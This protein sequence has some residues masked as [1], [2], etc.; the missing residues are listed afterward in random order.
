MVDFSPFNPMKVLYHRPSIELLLRGLMPPP[1]FITIDPSNRCNQN[2][3]WCFVHD[4]RTAT[5]V[6]LD[7]SVMRKVLK[8]VCRTV[9][10]IAYCGGGEPLMN[11]ATIQAMRWG[12][13]CH[14]QQGLVTNGTAYRSLTEADAVVDCCSFVRVSV[15]ASTPEIY[16]LLHRSNGFEY[17][18]AFIKRLVQR[19]KETA[20]NT[21][22]NV[23]YMICPTNHSEIVR[24]TRFFRGLDID[25]LIFKF[26]YSTYKGTDCGFDTNKF[27][28]EKGA[29]VADELKEAE[30][31]QDG[32]FKI[33]YRHPG[34][35]RSEKIVHQKNLY[36]RCYLQPLS[37]AGIAANGDLYSCCDRRGD[38]ILGNLKT[39]GFWEL[40][41]S[42]EHKK[43]FAG[44]K[45][46]DCPA[47]CKITEMNEIAERGFVKG[48]FDWNMI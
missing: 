5:P 11:S 22:V 44:V 35:F 17:A 15:D 47:R 1:I 18:I 31:Y 24:A 12:K 27:L 25:E 48:E 3:R 20:S 43:M 26:A 42:P 7:A 19:R 14:I 39:A 8:E 36:D 29:V 32:S 45:L 33:T 28:Q 4:Y 37:M 23:S 21:K 30:R 16:K 10:A 38:L 6:D 34:T 13:E 9:R 41:D 2:C 46:R 40:W